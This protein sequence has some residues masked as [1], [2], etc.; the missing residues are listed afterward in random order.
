[1]FLFPSLW[2]GLPL[3]LLSAMQLALEDP[4]DMTRMGVCYFS[5][6]R[7]LEQTLAV[8]AALKR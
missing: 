6:E 7:M 2:E 3:A 1:M 4:D 5:D 8:L